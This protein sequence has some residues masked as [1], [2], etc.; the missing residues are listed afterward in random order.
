MIYLLS[1]IGA[2][3][4]MTFLMRYSEHHD[5]NRYALN[6]WNYLAGALFS[7]V[8]LEDKRAIFSADLVT[9]FLGIVNGVGFVSALVLIQ[10]SIRRNG[11][12]LTTTFNRLG[13]L[14]PTILSAFLFKEIPAPLKIA[15]LVLCIFAIILM[16]SEDKKDRPSFMIGLFLVFIL[17][18]VLDFISRV[19]SLYYD[20]DSQ[21]CF[22][23]YTFL[24]ALVVSI[25]MFIKD[26]GKMTLRDAITGVGVGIPNQL[27]TILILRAATY[28]PAYIV[29]PTYSAGL[30]ILV[31]IINY[32]AFREV[33]SKKQYIATGIIGV[34]LV[35]LNLL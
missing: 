21:A 1:A 24:A 32:A 2:N 11:T 31:N 33:L 6:I 28:L 10:I 16:N 20:A 9:I 29:Y 12:P 15:G 3:L 7:I 27:T 5:G 19:Y 22:V 17:G 26:G 25:G 14:I 30:I 13:I 8:F 4:I 18:G 23:M 34:G 35:F